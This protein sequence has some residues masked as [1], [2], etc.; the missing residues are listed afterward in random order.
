[1]VGQDSGWKGF[2]NPVS[3]SQFESREGF[4]TGLTRVG[5]QLLRMDDSGSGTNVIK[6]LD[7]L[8][9]LSR[10]GSIRS[11]VHEPLLLKHRTRDCDSITELMHAHSFDGLQLAGFGL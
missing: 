11:D 10:R 1:M 3:F 5:A 4:L 6:S 7:K 9:N 8:N 2:S